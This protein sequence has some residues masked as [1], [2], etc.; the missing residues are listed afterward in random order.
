[1]LFR[2]QGYANGGNGLASSIS[3]SSIYYSGG[4]GGGA[5]SFIYGGGGIGGSGGGGNGGYVDYSGSPVGATDGSAN[6]GGGG[7]GA[8]NTGANGGSGIV[9]IRY[10]DAYDDAQST[11]GSPTYAK[12]GGYK[13]YTFTGSGT[14]TF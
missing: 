14:I 1:M 3:G 7:G 8:Y 11:T 4:G 9:I 13:I 5:T 12:T 10:S 2:S 6:T